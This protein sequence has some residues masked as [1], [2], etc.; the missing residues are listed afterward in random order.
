MHPL[1]AAERG[2]ADRARVRVQS[3]TGTVEADLETTDS[4]LRGVVSLPHGFGHA[5]AAHTLRVAGRLPAPNVNTLTDE[6][7]VEPV[8]GTS[9][10]NGVPVTVTPVE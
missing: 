1:D 3:R 7:L 9:I 2:L 8:L 4:M 5:A 10:L 6:L